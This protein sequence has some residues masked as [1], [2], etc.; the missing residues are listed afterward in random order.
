MGASVEA[1][2]AGF[3]TV[4][5]SEL[6]RSAF[7]PAAA[8]AKATSTARVGTAIALAFVRSP[9]TTALTALDLDE[10]SGGRFVLGLGSGVM[11]LNENWHNARFGKPAQHL[12]ET[13]SI[14]RQLVAE[15]HL[16]KPI[17]MDGDWERIR[18]RG[19]ARPF[20]PL[21]DRIPMR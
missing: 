2:V 4:S 12:R 9:M 6:H 18:L 10:L 7:V 11:R 5:V 17:E 13:V 14:I 16:G 8:I 1:E 3:E 21:R 19:F 20:A 15:A